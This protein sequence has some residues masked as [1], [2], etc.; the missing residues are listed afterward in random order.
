MQSSKTY[1]QVPNFNLIPLELQ[2]PTIS[3]RRRWFYLLF[4]IVLLAEV[5]FI[6]NLYREKSVFEAAT[7]SIQQQIP[8]LEEK[9]NLVSET[10]KLVAERQALENDWRGLL[11]K[12]I[13]WPQVLEALLQYKPGGVAISSVTLEEGRLNVKGTSSDYTG[14][15]EYR[16][17]LLDSPTISH[18][19]SLQ[20]T[21]SESV[22]SFSMVIELK[23]GWSNG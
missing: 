7:V 9:L 15:V 19:V 5:F 21:K 11:T 14:L 23:I 1:R 3:E 18:I 6:Q 16:R 17:L 10:G 8:Q 4:V 2:K 22:I 20:S 13:D 12:Q